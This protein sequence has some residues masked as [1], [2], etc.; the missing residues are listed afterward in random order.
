MYSVDHLDQF[1]LPNMY[2]HLSENAIVRLIRKKSKL[3]ISNTVEVFY[4][5]FKLGEIQLSLSEAK[6]LGTLEEFS[7]IIRTIEREKFMPV[8]SLYIQS[9]YLQT[10][11][12]SA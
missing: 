3:K 10:L 9:E 12:A 8:R 2:H 5:Q 6:L 1:D 7:G 11:P 4:K